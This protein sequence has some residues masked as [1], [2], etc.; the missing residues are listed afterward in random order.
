MRPDYGECRT[1]KIRA[2]ISLHRC[3]LTSLFVAAASFSSLA[4]ADPLAIGTIE[5]IDRANATITVLGQKYSVGSAKLIAGKKSFSAITGAQ[6]LSPEAV[7][8]IDCELTRDGKA[9]VATVNVLP[10]RNVPGATQVYVTGVV[11]SVSLTGKVKIGSL[12]IDTTPIVGA[13]LKAG[14]T[15]EFLG[16]QPVPNGVFVASSL[17]KR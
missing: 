5:K 9:K 2:R 14:D 6:L 4:S 13:S 12:T 10:E 15:A 17:A 8:W 11:S 3:V 1:M 7:V 16:T